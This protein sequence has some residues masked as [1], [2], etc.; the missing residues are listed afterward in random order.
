MRITRIDLSRRENIATGCQPKRD[1]VGL[2]SEQ[3]RVIR[4]I[5]QIRFPVLPLPSPFAV[6]RSPF[7]PHALPPIRP[8]VLPLSLPECRPFPLRAPTD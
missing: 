5:R 3:I 7:A 6:R 2:H 8:I 4:V 1:D